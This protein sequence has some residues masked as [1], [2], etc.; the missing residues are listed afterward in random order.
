MYTFNA[1]VTVGRYV[2]PTLHDLELTSSWQA[3]GDS[4]RV[5]LPGLRHKLE[6]LLKAGDPI[7]IECGYNGQY[8]TEFDGYVAEVLPNVPFE[9]RLEDESYWLKRQT[10]SGS[11]QSTTLKAVLAHIYPGV[12][13]KDVPD[14]TLAPFRIGPGSSK[15]KVLERLKEEY[16]LTVYF[17]GKTLYAGLA[18]SERRAT[19]TV[20]YHLQKNVAGSDLTFRRAADMRLGVKAISVLANNTSFNAHVGDTDGD[21]LTLHFYNVTTK[22]AL[23]ALAKERIAGMKFDGYRGSLTAFGWPRVEHGQAALILDDLY[24][25]RRARVF[26]DQVRTTV[27]KS[28][29]FRRQITLGRKAD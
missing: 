17:R 11:W 1:R 22:A 28:G 26:V 4:G 29:G 9:L 18:Y 10:T 12:V 16:G 8:A 2:M 13:S 3:L 6:N 15:F 14:V 5:R 19:E 27:S 20:V 21:Q 24:P 25:Q 23:E 7:K